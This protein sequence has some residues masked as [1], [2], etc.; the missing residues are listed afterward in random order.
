MAPSHSAVSLATIQTYLQTISKQHSI[1][2]NIYAD[3]DRIHV[4]TDLRSS[5]LTE[6]PE[7][8]SP[9]PCLGKVYIC[10]PFMLLLAVAALCWAHSRS[11]QSARSP[12]ENTAW[13]RT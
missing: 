10:R 4:D 5:D 1:L 13:V 11:Q 9:E 8:D 12:S 3:V 2:L 6:Y 7:P